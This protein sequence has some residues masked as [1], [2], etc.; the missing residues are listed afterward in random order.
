VLVSSSS[1]NKEKPSPEKKAIK[2]EL[3]STELEMWKK[4]SPPGVEKP[5]ADERRQTPKLLLKRVKHEPT[6]EVVDEEEMNKKKKKRKEIKVEPLVEEPDECFEPSAK[7]KLAN[8]TATL[9][10]V[11]LP[12][13]VELDAVERR[14]KRQQNLKPIKKSHQ[15][16]STEDNSSMFSARKPQ[17]VEN[18]TNENN[19]EQR[20]YQLPVV[21]PRNS[22]QTKKGI[23]FK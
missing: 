16:E 12:F 23:L 11:A 18:S 8:G 14:E 15:K 2:L 9:R 22:F 21:Q 4:G 19:T 13:S 17:K 5:D 20:V 1:R 10:P 7:K 6:E 3:E